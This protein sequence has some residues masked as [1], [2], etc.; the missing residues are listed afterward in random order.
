MVHRAILGS[1]E[2]FVGGLI[3][4]FGGKSLLIAPSQVAG[5]RSVRA[6]RL[7]QGVASA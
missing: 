4:H 7:R 3:E 6:R 2:R 1:L 5:I